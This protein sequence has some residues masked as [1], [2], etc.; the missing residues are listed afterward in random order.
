MRRTGFTSTANP[1]VRQAPIK[2]RVCAVKS[3][4]QPA[5]RRSTGPSKK[6]RDAVLERDRH[7]CQRCGRSGL[8]DGVPYSLQHRLPRGRQGANTMANLVAVC[9]SAT[10]PG[11][12]HDWMEHDDRPQATNDGWLVPSWDDVTPENW[13][14]WRFGRMWSMPGATGWDD[15]VEPHPLQWRRAAA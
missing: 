13:P 9:G 4:A 8:G 12:C 7:A 3:T 14:V 6:M 11:M 15:D 1:L 5:A 10:T 2:R